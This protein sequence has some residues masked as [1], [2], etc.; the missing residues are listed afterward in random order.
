M[1]DTLSRE[2]VLDERDAAQVVIDTSPKAPTIILERMRFKVILCDMALRSLDAEAVTVHP[3]T[4]EC[5][6]DRNGSINADRYV[7]MCGWADPDL[8]SVQQPRDG[9]VVPRVPTTEMIEAGRKAL[10]QQDPKMV[11]HARVIWLWNDMLAARPKE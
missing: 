10:Q 8:P 1:T 4:E 5:G 7:C 3:Y 6:F 2:Q 9:V 11:S